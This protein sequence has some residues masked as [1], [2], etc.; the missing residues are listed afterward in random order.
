[1]WEEEPDYP[2]ADLLADLGGIIGLYLGISFCE[3][4]YHI[5]F[6]IK[7]IQKIFSGGKYFTTSKKLLRSSK[8]YST[9][10]KFT[11]NAAEI[12]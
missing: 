8:K 7:N 9:H 1:M 12:F 2:V 3:L 4:I 6:M 10:E 11:Y 5:E